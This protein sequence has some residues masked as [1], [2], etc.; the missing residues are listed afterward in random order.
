MLDQQQLCGMWVEG[1]SCEVGIGGWVVQV[2]PNEG[3]S[4]SSRQK[5]GM[6]GTD[7][8]NFQENKSSQ[9]GL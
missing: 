6:K 4:E 1:S 5:D 2:R 9:I 7:W 8:K 3:L